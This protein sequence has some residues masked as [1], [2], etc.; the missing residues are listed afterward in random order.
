MR[1]EEHCF[2]G[3]SRWVYFVEMKSRKAGEPYKL[4]FPVG[5]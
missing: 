4:H 2:K 1:Q 3:V 5:E